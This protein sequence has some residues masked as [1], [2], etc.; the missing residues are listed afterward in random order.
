M[1]ELLI[2]SIHCDRLTITG[3][4]DWFRRKNNAGEFKQDS[5][6]LRKLFNP[7]ESHI[8][9]HPNKDNGMYS[10]NFI[11]PIK[12]RG[13]SIF[14]QVNRQFTSGQRDFRVDLNPAKLAE[15]EA[16]W[17]IDLL[18]NVSEKR[19]TRVD[20]ALNFHEDLKGYILTEGR[21][22]SSVEFKD[23]YG[24]IETL[25]RGSRNSDSYLKMYDKK[26]ERESKYKEVDYDWWRIE[27]TIKDGKADTWKE[28]E[29]FKGI[30][31]ATNK[32]VFPEEV[33][34]RWKSNV[35]CI[36]NKLMSLDDFPKNDRT[37]IRK[38]LKLVTYEGEFNIQEEIKKAPYQ[39]MMESALKEISYYLK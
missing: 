34:A 6:V 35:L 9:H 31:L 38:L 14:V 8:T 23:R 7:M 27:E 18:G 28:Y 39:E 37:E 17:L 2:E 16:K 13:S 3:R 21:Q 36:M 26:K 10:D 11:I 5:N 1:S 19:V 29:W 25:Y 4:L 32:P 12:E 22:R 15:E 33:K 20:M 30:V 24:N